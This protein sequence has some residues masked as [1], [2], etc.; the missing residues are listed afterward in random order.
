MDIVLYYRIAKR[1]L[2]EP[3]PTFDDVRKFQAI[4]EETEGY[5]S[6]E[7]SIITLDLKKRG[8]TDDQI[9]GF[10]VFFICMGIEENWL[11]QQVGF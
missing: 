1:L 9:N 6:A 2:D 10:S 8:F 4:W 11:L 5:D 7:P 3:Y